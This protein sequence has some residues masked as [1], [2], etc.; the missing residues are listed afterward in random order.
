MTYELLT[1][2]AG[3]AFV[4]SITPGPNN[5]MLMTSGAN[6]GILRTVPHMF[7]IGL[8]FTLMVFLVGIGLVQVF[9]AYPVSHTILKTASV[10]YLLYLAA[11]IAL[12]TPKAPDA[13]ASTASPM[14]F[15]Q[16]AAFQWVNPK[17]WSMALTAVTVYNPTASLAGVITVSL[18][19]GAINMPTISSWTILGQQLRRFLTNSLRFR[20]FNGVMALLLVATLY[21]IVFPST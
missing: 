17:A 2:L 12:Q 14:T 21:P 16:A 13:P 5:L 7:G 19:F 15:L 3:F 20:I 8:G 1:A 18:V 10:G 4:S 9:D 6:F 11:K